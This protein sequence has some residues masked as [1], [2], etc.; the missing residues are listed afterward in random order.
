[1]ETTETNLEPLRRKRVLFVCGLHKSGTSLLHTLL[2]EH[3]EISGFRETGVPQDEGQHLQSVFPPASKFGGPGRFAFRPES[4]LDE[5][6]ALLSQANQDKLRREWMRHWDLSK[7]VLVEKSP[8]NLVRSRFLQSIFENSYFVLIKRH[9]ISVALSTQRWT[10][11]SVTGLLSHWLAA[12]ARW[13][14]DRPHLRHSMEIRYEQLVSDPVTVLSGIARF[15]GVEPTGF[16]LS[17]IRSEAQPEYDS[18]LRKIW[19]PL[20]RPALN[21]LRLL[22][23]RSIR[24]FGYE[25]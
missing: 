6:S 21:F 2:R 17:S 16:D 18:G 5:T 23:G 7:P 13:E 19:G 10:G 14:S 15:I 22:Y 12:H 25:L 8:I 11:T 4:F 1:M 20:T 9:P 24:S 3:P